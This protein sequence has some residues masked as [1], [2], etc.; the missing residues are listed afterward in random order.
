MKTMRAVVCR[1]IG[2]LDH[3]VFQEVEYPVPSPTEAVVALKAA[4]I[5]HRDW[6]IV[7][8]LYARIRMPVILGSD[9]AGTVH[10]VG[11]V[12]MDE[13]LGREV[14]INPSL[15]W[16]TDPRAQDAA[17]RILGM[18]DNGTLAE[19][20]KVPVAS[21]MP[22]PAHMSMEEAAAL[23]LAGLT[24]YRALF[25]QGRLRSDE[26]VLITGVGGGVASIAL[27]MA[28]ASGAQVVVTSSS[29]DKIAR[30]VKVGA[31]I[32]I[33]TARENAFKQAESD[34]RGV[35]GIDLVVDGIGGPLFNELLGTVKPGGRVVV[36]GATA[37]N[38]PMI[39]LRRI[40]WKQ[41][42]VQGSTMGTD[43]NFRAMA[44]FV[45]AHR[46]RPPVDQVFPLINVRQAFERMKDA[47]QF[48]KI[49]IK[50]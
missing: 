21:L 32:G 29:D 40:F 43:E 42:T 46:L 6:W 2:S 17:Y 49:V 25:V 10:S 24:A 23:P 4:A 20:V 15:A 12:G 41:I 11:D 5:N 48:G 26:A 27:Q 13:W 50:M 28:V 36:Y 22:K 30:A 37:G 14:I 18:P 35:G 1:D 44:A 33:N 7:Q 8:G 19:Y 16:G 45:E 47:Q 9:G 38:P 31:R 39:D 34:L 3:L